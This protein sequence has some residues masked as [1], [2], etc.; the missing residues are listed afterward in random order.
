MCRAQT[1]KHL[2]E[3][4]VSAA[5]KNGVAS[6]FGVE[7][8]RIAR[9]LNSVSALTSEQDR[10]SDIICGKCLNDAE[11]RRLSLEFTR[12]GIYYQNYV[13]HVYCLYY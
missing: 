13:F 11:K 5:T 12:N 9:K 3:S 4:A 6:S 7:P 8:C 2:V 1:C 10:G